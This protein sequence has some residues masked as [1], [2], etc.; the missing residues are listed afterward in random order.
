MDST[1]FPGKP[2]A[3][4]LNK[5]MIGHV[6]DRVR[7]CDL[8]NK[9]VVA[10]CDQEIADYINSING[11][12][13]MTGNHH[14][15]ATERCAEALEILEEEYKEKYDIVVM[16]QGDEPMVNPEMIGDI[17]NP[18]LDNNDILVANLYGKIESIKELNDKNVVKVVCDLESNAMYFSREPI[19]NAGN[20]INLQS[21]KQYGIIAFERNFLIKYINMEPTYLEKA[22]SIDMLRI[23]EHGLRLK[24]IL[25]KYNI[26]TVDTPDELYQVEKLMKKLPAY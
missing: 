14:T 23:L 18:I 15:R 6:Y 13:V 5:P 9:T 1:R 21:F 8:L 19:P 25:T 10:T 3:N 20:E 4:I 12:Y 24:M 26:F 7:K 22:E 11:Q 17:V 2:L 16:V